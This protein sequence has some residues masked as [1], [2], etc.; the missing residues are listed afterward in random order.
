MY[1]EFMKAIVPLVFLAFF[2]TPARSQ[3]TVTLCELLRNPNEYN[4]KVVTVRATL[5]FGF[6][7]SQLYCLDCLESGRAWLDLPSDLEEDQ[8][9]RKALKKLPREAGIVNLT[10]QGVFSSG[11]TYGHENGYQ[12]QIR[13]VRIS[14]VAVIQK[15][16]RP[17]AE[18]HK[19]E[20]RWACGGSNPR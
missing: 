9:S 13:A 6:E 16:V 7:W 1:F 17:L 5:R 3:T 4:G 11:G 19:V 8:I 18:E 2:V 15:G 10:V 12:F 14:D 20:Q